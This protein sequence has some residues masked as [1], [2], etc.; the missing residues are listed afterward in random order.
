MYS[1]AERRLRELKTI[2]FEIEKEL[3]GCPQG[4]IHVSKRGKNVQYYLRMEKDEKTG[5]YLKK[6]DSKIK[7]YLDKSYLER[8]KRSISNEISSIE[9]F[10]KKA[11]GSVEQ[12]RKLYSENN[13]DIK[14]KIVPFDCSDEDFVA[15]WNAVAY[16]PKEIIDGIQTYKTERGEIVRSK[17]ELNIANA[18]YARGIPYKYEKPFTIAG[19]YVIFPDFTIL[20][21]RKRKEYIWEHR[22]MMDDREYSKH[23]VRRV[24]DYMNTNYFLGD[25]LIITEETSTQALGTNEI[26]RII[27]HYFV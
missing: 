6:A 1:E 23:S 2:R 12:I 19:G 21:V 26:N 16:Q 7:K 18:L 14:T 10:L 11:G 22:G 3:K 15:A 9:S 4:K 20:N 8:V 24:K 27:D 13:A 17:S 25:N 5:I